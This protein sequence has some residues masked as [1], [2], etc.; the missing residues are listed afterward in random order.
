VRVMM[1]TPQE[2]L[3]AW[4]FHH[5]TRNLC[6]KHTKLGNDRSVGEVGHARIVP[7]V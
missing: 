1:K 6:V 4:K 2:V 5:S 3:E 7:V